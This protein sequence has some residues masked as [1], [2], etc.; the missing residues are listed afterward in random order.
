MMAEASLL[1]LHA[2]LKEANNFSEIL[3]LKQQKMDIRREDAVSSRKQQEE[4]V[5]M[6]SLEKENHTKVL[7]KLVERLY[8]KEDPNC[9]SCTVSL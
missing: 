9:S 7:A 2:T 1:S 8:P 6:S 4:R 3:E 5:K